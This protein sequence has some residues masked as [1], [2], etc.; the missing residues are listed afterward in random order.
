MSRV[1]SLI[2]VPHLGMRD[3]AAG[4][5]LKNTSFRSTSIELVAPIRCELTSSAHQAQRQPITLARNVQ[6]HGS[7]VIAQQV[8]SMYQRSPLDEQ[9]HHWTLRMG[10]VAARVC[11]D[12]GAA[13]SFRPGQPGS[14]DTCN[15]HSSCTWQYAHMIWDNIHSDMDNMIVSSYDEDVGHVE[16]H[17]QDALANEDLSQNALLIA[18]YALF[19]WRECLD[20]EEAEKL[21]NLAMQLD[22]TRDFE[23]TTLLSLYSLFLS[24]TPPN[25]CKGTLGSY[26]DNIQHQMK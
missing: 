13:C 12:L 5:H 17:F 21:L 10:D 22:T 3:T 11:D 26:R 2:N 19:K 20:Y 24:S 16:K 18:D 1:S 7:S 8:I 14:A 4:R 9:L 6:A 25:V 15:S 23:R